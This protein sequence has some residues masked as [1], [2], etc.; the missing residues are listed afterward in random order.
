MEVVC[1]TAE[2]EGLAF[3]TIWEKHGLS[4]SEDR[5]LARTFGLVTER[6]ADRVG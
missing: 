2:A 3:L 6:E 1:A 5:V 4:V